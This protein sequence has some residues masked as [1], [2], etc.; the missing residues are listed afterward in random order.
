M[1]ERMSK[2]ANGRGLNVRFTKPLFRIEL[3]LEQSLAAGSGGSGRRQRPTTRVFAKRIAADAPVG[4][5]PVASQPES[6][7]E[8]QITEVMGRS[9]DTGKANKYR[10]RFKAFVS[11]DLGSWV[12]P[13]FQ[14]DQ[15]S[16]AVEL[17]VKPLGVGAS[18]TV[19]VSLK[20]PAG[21]TTVFAGGRG[22][23]DPRGPLVDM[24]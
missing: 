12:P 19:Q 20:R 7:P 14:V 24:S 15:V 17:S 1:V 23:A 6:L 5:V 3:G 18:T 2:G 13:G 22:P 8:G 21:H 10:E 16:F 9:V 4:G 11:Q